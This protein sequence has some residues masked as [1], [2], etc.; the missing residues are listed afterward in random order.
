[1]IR[2]TIFNENWHEVFQEEVRKLYPD[3]MHGAIK[4]FLG[5]NDDIE[6]QCVTMYNDKGEMDATCGITDELLENTDVLIWWSHG[7]YI[8]VADETVQKVCKAVNCG[9]G[10]IF[11]HSAHISKPFSR[12]MGTTCYLSWREDGNERLWNICP[13]HPI[14]QGV[15][16]YFDL[17]PEE[18]YAEP[19][20]VPAPEE[21]LMIGAY[22]TCEVFRSACTYQRGNGRIF[23]FQPGHESYPTF[24]NENVQKIIT[25]AVRWVAPTY[26]FK[27][28]LCPEIFPIEL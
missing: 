5:K 9:M 2:V 22:A 27:E 15:G 3:G 26:R 7:K 28:R 17:K 19:F 18:V 23:Y 12:L 14:M 1:M 8:D 10:A 6:V 20:D 25:N 13:S 21:L 24:Y 16:E 4:D 11:L